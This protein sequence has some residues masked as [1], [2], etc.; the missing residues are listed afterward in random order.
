MRLTDI[1]LLA[2]LGLCLFGAVDPAAAAHFLDHL[3]AQLRAMLP[4]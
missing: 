2:L 1:I 4:W 3:A